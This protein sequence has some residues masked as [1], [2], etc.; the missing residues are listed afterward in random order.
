VWEVL[1][2]NISD[3]SVI[4]FAEYKIAYFKNNAS[5]DKEIHKKLIIASYNIQL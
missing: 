5:L 3:F 2:N 4:F 1:V